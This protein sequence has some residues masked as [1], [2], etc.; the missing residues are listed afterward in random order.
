MSKPVSNAEIDYKHHDPYLGV[1]AEH[2]DVMSEAVARMAATA[3]TAARS[4]ARDDLVAAEEAMAAVENR[5]R[6]FLAALSRARCPAYLQGADA[7]LHDALKLM[8]D[9]GQRGAAAARARDGEQLESAA[10]EMDAAFD[11]IEA[12]AARIVDSRSGAAR[13]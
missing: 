12:A 10:S 2:A 7:Q 8:I 1:L 4:Q 5:A 13:P 6:S 3:G 9:G 11:D